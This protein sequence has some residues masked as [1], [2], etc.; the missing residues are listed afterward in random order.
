[1]ETKFLVETDT[2]Y[3]SATSNS[4]KV[5]TTSNLDCNHHRRRHDDDDD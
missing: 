1:M 4:D 3:T 5:T 2:M